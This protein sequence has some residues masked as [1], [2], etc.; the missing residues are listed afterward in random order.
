MRG[1]HRSSWQ[2]PWAHTLTTPRKTGEHG[3]PETSRGES[4]GHQLLSKAVVAIKSRCN[5]DL[6]MCFPA[7]T[8]AITQNPAFRT[9][10]HHC[11]ST[12]STGSP[13]SSPGVLGDPVTISTGRAA[14]RWT[15][16]RSLGSAVLLGHEQCRWLLQDPFLYLG[17]LHLHVPAWRYTWYNF[18]MW[19]FINCAPLWRVLP[20]EVILQ[21][22]KPC[23]WLSFR[24]WLLFHIYLKQTGWQITAK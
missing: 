18:S 12:S 23:P 8:S 4:H 16:P 24:I 10:L 1:W 14:K 2:S 3:P 15:P 21:L 7:P 9:R 19:K 5:Y 22:T 6:T 17:L 20:A 13:A 11:G